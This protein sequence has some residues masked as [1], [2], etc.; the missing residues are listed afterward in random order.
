[1]GLEVLAAVTKKG[2]R[3]VESNKEEKGDEVYYGS[4]AAEV[5]AHSASSGLHCRDLSQS[6]IEIRVK[7]LSKRF[8]K[9]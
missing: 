8:S 1:V 5:C 2:T 6:D 9:I 3:A 7:V 4:A